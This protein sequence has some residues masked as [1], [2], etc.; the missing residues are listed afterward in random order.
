MEG[1]PPRTL[2]PTLAVDDELRQLRAAWTKSAGQVREAMDR[3]GR[4]EA[5]APRPVRVEDFVHSPDACISGARISDGRSC[6]SA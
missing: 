5:T 1:S 4:E 2:A 3:Y 6:V